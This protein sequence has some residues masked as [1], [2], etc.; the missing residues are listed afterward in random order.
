MQDQDQDQDQAGSFEEKLM[1]NL[2]LLI[3]LQE[4]GQRI[5]LTTDQILK[6]WSWVLGNT[7]P[8]M[9]NFTSTCESD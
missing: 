4:E 7:K 3:S 2:P 8:R 9:G 5:G 1:G 6:I